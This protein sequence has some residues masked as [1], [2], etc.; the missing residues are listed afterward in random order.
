M[1]Y[2]QLKKECEKQRLKMT[3]LII[4]CGGTNSSATH[5]KNGAIP[6]SDIV[7]K[8]AKRLGVST[9]YLLGN[10]PSQAISTGSGAAVVG[11]NAVVTIKNGHE[12]A[13]STHEKDLLKVFNE[14]DG[15][16]QLEIMNLVYQIE[17]KIKKRGGN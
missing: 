4:E 16:E 12:R 17:E 1:F 9:D 2:E 15:K 6:K 10:T 13:L 14:A 11:D 5:W 7:L 8:L 3:P